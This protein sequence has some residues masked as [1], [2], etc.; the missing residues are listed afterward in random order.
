MPG[1]VTAAERIAAARTLLFVPA[2]RPE[3]FDKALAAGADLVIVDL[4][5]AVAPAMKD[6]ARA[7]L[8][9]WLSAERPV[10]VRVNVP[11]SP[12][13][14]EDLALCAH[15]GVLAVVLPKASAESAMLAAAAAAKPIVAL[16][17]TAQGIADI[18]AVA[19]TEGV[20]RLAMGAIDLAGDLGLGAE[21]SLVDPFRLQM[22]LASRLA[23]IAAPVDGVTAAFKDEARL[24]S[25]V[26]RARALGFS[27]KLCIHPLQLAAVRV[28]FAATPEQIAWAQRVVEADAGAAGRAVQVDGEMVDKPVVDRARRILAAR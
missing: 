20:A 27:G 24:A 28:G 18:A 17:E 11:A 12:Q 25:D 21:D 1:V 19:G 22:T 3:R 8:A 10:L 7:N 15:A 4:E 9:D 2:D 26:S 14:S 6:A 23:G 5:D 16:I 13:F